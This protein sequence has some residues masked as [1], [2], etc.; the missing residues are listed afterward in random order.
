LSGNFLCFSALDFGRLEFPLKREET[1]G[2][3]VL[4]FGKGE[5]RI[6]VVVYEKLAFVFGESAGRY[7]ASGVAE[8]GGGAEKLSGGKTEGVFFI[9]F[10]LGEFALEV[11]DGCIAGAGIVLDG[12]VDEI[13]FFFSWCDPFNVIEVGFLDAVVFV[14]V[15]HVGKETFLDALKIAK[16]AV[17]IGDGFAGAQGGE[18]SGLDEAEDGFEVGFAVGLVVDLNGGGVLADGFGGDGIG[19]VVSVEFAEGADAGGE[20]E[21]TFGTWARDLFGDSFVWEL[22]AEVEDEVLV[23][24]RET[25]EFVEAF[26]IISG[27]WLVVSGKGGRRRDFLLRP[28]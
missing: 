23:F 9:D 27:K 3:G 4:E 5:G 2:G 25:G 6:H 16:F 21:A 12:V 11:V 22:F 20:V 19:V 26:H 17:E 24:L 18:D 1:F 14:A 13:G 8:K 28:N 7:D 10:E 15:F